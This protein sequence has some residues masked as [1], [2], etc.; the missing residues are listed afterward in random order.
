[1]SASSTAYERNAPA[2]A[3]VEAALAPSRHSV[4][5]L[6]DAPGTTYD[7]L[8][9]ATEADLAIVG[10]GY[11]GL[12]TAVLAKRRNPGARV[13]LLEA[14]TVGWA[15]SGRNGGFC[16]ASLTHGEENGRSRWPEEYDELERLGAA[17]LDAFQADVRDLGLD[18]QFE[19]TGQLAV[20]VE[21]HQVEWLRSSEHYL[22]RDAVRA[23]IDS[24]LFLAGEWSRD[25]CALVHPARLARELARVAASLGVEIHE[26]TRVTGLDAPTRGPVVVSTTA[27][28]VTADRVALAT[29]VFPSLLR[30]TRM[31]TVPVYDYVLMT[32]PLSHAQLASIGWGN[33]QGLGDLANQFH[34]SRLTA[35]NRILWGGYDAI[36]PTGGRVRA[37]YEERPATFATLASH[38]LAAFPQLEGVTFTHRWAGAID[39]S[40]QFVAFHGL[41]SRGRVA[42]AAGFTGLGVGATRFAAEV[43]LDRLSGLSTERTRLDMVRRKPLPFPP[44]PLASVGIN[45]TRWSLDRADHRE[46]RRNLFLKTLDAVGLGFDS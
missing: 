38:F 10:G 35:D 25:D 28:S 15:A 27:G 6:E 44:E 26:G 21:P 43:M 1:M 37:S 45:A 13:V 19:R 11:C 12:W 29:N 7:A 20:A 33:R 4:Y 30:R 9:G 8:A 46:G 41:A 5:W 16:E 3:A 32:E 24:P 34:Y 18:C 42:Y 40:T 14:N 39:T 17:N 22:D 23:E 36:Y 2:P 31:L